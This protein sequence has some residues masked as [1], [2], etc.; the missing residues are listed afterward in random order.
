MTD[1][2]PLEPSY[3]DTVRQQ[4][5]AS[6]DPSYEALVLNKELSKLPETIFKN[7]FLPYLCGEK[8]LKDSNNIIATWVA[9]AG[10]PANKV[11][12]IDD[13]GNDL[14]EVPALI[15]TNGSVDTLNPNSIPMSTIIENYA[16]RAATMPIMGNN[17]LRQALDEKVSQITQVKINESTEDE[18]YKI[19][20]RYGKI[21]DSGTED[22]KVSSMSN[23]EFDF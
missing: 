21:K 2:T 16:I 11:Q 1:K 17:F 7:V 3:L 13:A 8:D 20:V 6:I 9:I 12:I 10:T 15:D 18:W 4:A 14:F 19:F 5:E 23:D 22:I